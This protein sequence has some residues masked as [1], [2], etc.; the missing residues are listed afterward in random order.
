MEYLEKFPFIDKITIPKAIPTDE[1]TPIIVSDD[2]T[3]EFIIVEIHKANITAKLIRL[4][5][6]LKMQEQKSQLCSEQKAKK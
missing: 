5:R 4:N 2:E 1:K 3:E 6:L